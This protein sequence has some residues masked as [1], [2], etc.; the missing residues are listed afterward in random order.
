M[1]YLRTIKQMI[2]AGGW[3][4]WAALAISTLFMGLV[5]KAMLFSKDEEE[6]DAEPQ[7]GTTEVKYLFDTAKD[8]NDDR[9]N[10]KKKAL[11]EILNQIDPKLLAKYNDMANEIMAL[12]TKLDK[13]EIL[14]SKVPESTQELIEKRNTLS[15]WL[16]TQALN[17]PQLRAELQEREAMEYKELE[18]ARENAQMLKW[19]RAKK[20]ALVEQALPSSKF[21]IWSQMNDEYNEEPD[22]ELQQGKQA[23]IRQSLL[24]WIGA[25]KTEQMIM[26]PLRQARL[27]YMIEVKRHKQSNSYQSELL[28]RVNQAAAP[29]ACRAYEQDCQKNVQS[30]QSKQRSEDGQVTPEQAMQV[31]QVM[32]RMEQA[33]EKLQRSIAPKLWAKVEEDLKDLRTFWEEEDAYQVAQTYINVMQIE[34]MREAFGHVDSKK[35]HKL[36]RSISQV[37]DKDKKAATE[38]FKAEKMAM[39]TGDP[40]KR[41]K[42]QALTKTR[43]DEIAGA[44]GVAIHISTDS[45]TGDEVVIVQRPPTFDREYK[46]KSIADFKQELEDEE[47]AEKAEAETVTVPK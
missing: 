29:E 22:K 38:S 39:L 23:D 45:E 5:I 14:S 37:A 35:L 42:K 20:V 27:Q 3:V 30:M 16:G 1:S 32:Q 17:T 12:A 46:Q 31:Q 13:K 41:A 33:Q 10:A 9:A 24:G 18:Q 2:P 6:E 28:V 26:K 21:K 11:T 36:W 4:Y 43:V 25:E 8:Q 15:K 44:T 47:A 19:L 7:D 40:A 34:V